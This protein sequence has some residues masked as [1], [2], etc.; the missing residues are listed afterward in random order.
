MPIVIECCYRNK[1][2][3]KFYGNDKNRFEI[4]AITIEANEDALKKTV[5]TLWLTFI[6]NVKQ[7]F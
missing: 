7:L 3:C 2:Y 1:P 5:I 4:K 6:S